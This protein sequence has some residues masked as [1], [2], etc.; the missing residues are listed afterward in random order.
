MPKKKVRNT[1]KAERQ[2]QAKARRKVRRKMKAHQEAKRAGT[3]SKGRSHPH[4]RT[5]ALRGTA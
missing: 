1:K 2:A 4:R 3:K 5:S